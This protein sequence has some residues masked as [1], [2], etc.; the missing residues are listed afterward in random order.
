M[1]EYKAKS[2][3]EIKREV[4]GSRRDINDIHSHIDDVIKDSVRMSDLYKKILTENPTTKDGETE[5][6]K[7]RYKVFK[8][9]GEKHKEYETGLEPKRKGLG[10]L[11]KELYN[12]TENSKVNAQKANEVARYISIPSAKDAMHRVEKTSLSDARFTDDN[13]KQ[14]QK[15]RMESK[16]RTQKQIH[17]LAQ[18][19]AM[20]LAYTVPVKPTLEREPPEPL[21]ASM[22]KQ[23][24]IQDSK[25]QGYIPLAP[26]SYKI[27]ERVG[28]QKPQEYIRPQQDD[29]TTE[30]EENKG[31]EDQ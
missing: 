16:I 4:N 23:P 15:S 21:Q 31:S 26:K 8:T 22:E 6:N 17:E 29:K 30:Y 14:A 27:N 18:I 9:I 20:N 13:R 12:R 7:T 11:T 24:P 10:G 2:K 3:G 1:R 19:V 25:R 28:Y 5:I